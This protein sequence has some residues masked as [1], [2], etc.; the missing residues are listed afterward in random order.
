MA[1]FYHRKYED[2]ISESSSD[3]ED[4]PALTLRSLTSRPKVFLSHTWG[5]NLDGTDNHA[6]ASRLNRSLQA[7]GVLTWFDDD[8]MGHDLLSSMSGGIDW[9][10]IFLILVT[11][12]YIDKCNG[13]SQNNCRREFCYASRRKQAGAILLVVVESECCNQAAWTGPFGF[14][15]SN[16]LYV[17][18]SRT[19]VPVKVGQAIKTRMLSIKKTSQN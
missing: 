7:Q 13:S 9:A 15:C 11:K 5:L 10:D 6:M 16:M 19:L 4:I 3:E 12:A 17:D 8:D 2:L 14:L 1:S 18:C